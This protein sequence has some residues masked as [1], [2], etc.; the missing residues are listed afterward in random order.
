MIYIVWKKYCTSEHFDPAIHYMY[1][2]Q[3]AFYIINMWGV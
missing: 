3:Y 2:L 1:I